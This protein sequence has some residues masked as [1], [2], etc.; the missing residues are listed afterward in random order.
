MNSQVGPSEILGKILW[1][2]LYTGSFWGRCHGFHQILK[3]VPDPQSWKTY[4]FR[5]FS[6][7]QT[8]LPSHQQDPGKNRMAGINGSVV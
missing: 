2:C 5:A 7:R 3:G 8:L 1:G 6:V 4:Y